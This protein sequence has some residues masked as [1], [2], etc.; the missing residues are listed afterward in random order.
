MTSDMKETLRQAVIYMDKATWNDI[1]KWQSGKSDHKQTDMGLSTSINPMEGYLKLS[2]R[3]L[4]DWEVTLD[5][6]LEVAKV[7]QKAKNLGAAGVRLAPRSATV[8]WQGRPRR[9]PSHFTVVIAYSSGVEKRIRVPRSRFYQLAK[10]LRP[11]V[12]RALVQ[13][14]MGS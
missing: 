8:L 6:G 13:S 12:E 11:A 14:V 1:K 7:F 3:D 5:F 10:D 2:G 4:P 9:D